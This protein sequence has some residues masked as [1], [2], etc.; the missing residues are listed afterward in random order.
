MSKYDFTKKNHNYAEHC[1]RVVNL[2]KSKTGRL[3]A[4][5]ERPKA[6]DFVV[7]RGF[8]TSDG[9]WAQG[10]YGYSTREKAN[11]RARYLSYGK[12]KK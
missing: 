6:K 11:N 7:G 5:I 9:R 10:E 3:Y 1:W 4:V 8:D 2:H 12:K